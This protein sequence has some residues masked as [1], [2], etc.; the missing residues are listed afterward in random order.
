MNKRSLLLLVLSFCLLHGAD[1]KEKEEVLSMG[2]IEEVSQLVSYI[3]RVIAYTATIYNLHHGDDGFTFEPNK[4][5]SM[6]RRFG[7]VKYLCISNVNDQIAR[8]REDISICCFLKKDAIA[9]EYLAGR[10]LSTEADGNLLFEWDEELRERFKKA[11]LKVRFAT[12]EEKIK[13]KEE[14]L[15]GAIKLGCHSKE[16]ALAFL[17]Q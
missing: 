9:S 11:D 10:A 2:K 16:K 14:L 3:G 5:N 8:Q 12:Q 1:E 7:I 6:G 13:I 4:E 17:S 15:N